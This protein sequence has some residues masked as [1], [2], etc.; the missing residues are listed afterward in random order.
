MTRANRAKLDPVPC[1]G[2]ISRMYGRRR[3]TAGLH[4]CFISQLLEELVPLVVL[5][6]FAAA[7]PS[8]GGMNIPSFC[9]VGGYPSRSRL[10]RHKQP[11]KLSYRIHSRFGRQ[12]PN[13]LGLN[14]A[15]ARW[16]PPFRCD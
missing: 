14:Q 5:V 6:P 13:P 3:C 10:P 7:P 16:L 2:K 11:S 8:H 9:R 4:F 12:A 1:V 15:G